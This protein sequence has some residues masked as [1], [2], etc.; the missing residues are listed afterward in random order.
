LRGVKIKHDPV[1]LATSFAAAARV[2]EA[3]T[4]LP[5]GFGK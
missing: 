1:F 5:D 4:P 2:P 3:G